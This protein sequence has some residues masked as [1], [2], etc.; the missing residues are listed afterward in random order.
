MASDHVAARNMV[1]KVEHP[2]EGEIN[3]LGFPVKLSGTPQE[4]R[5]PPPLL[6]QHTR[7]LVDELGLSD[8]Y[9]ELA[10]G[11]AFSQ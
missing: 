7:D 4:V 2:V 8:R 3:T 5:Y 1:M 10:G 11:G 9:D 6:G